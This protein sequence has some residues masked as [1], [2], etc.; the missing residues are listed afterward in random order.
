MIR[1]STLP[2]DDRDDR[3]LP[4]SAR[5]QRAD[6]LPNGVSRKP[7][8]RSS[9]M[10]TAGDTVTINQGHKLVTPPPIKLPEPPD[11][12]LIIG[13]DAGETTSRPMKAGH[14]MI[15]LSCRPHRVGWDK[16]ADRRTQADWSSATAEGAIGDR[17]YFPWAVD[18]LR[19]AL[20]PKQPVVVRTNRQFVS[21]DGDYFL[22]DGTFR[23]RISREL[24]LSQAVDVLIHE[25]AH[26]LSWHTCVGG[27]ARSRRISKNEFD[28][29]AHGPKWGIAYSKV[30]QCF[31]YEI[32]PRLHAGGLTATRPQT[33]RARRKG[34]KKLPL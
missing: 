22:V 7:R 14:Q 2:D 1:R 10:R 16:P 18:A 6:A 31:T 33:R 15:C 8:G 12:G 30:Y 9:R 32:A 4:K 27:L 28:R 13:E 5:A 21:R 19:T 24:S 29:L 17:R 11:T 26:A 23:I 25:W 20:P 3:E 34:S